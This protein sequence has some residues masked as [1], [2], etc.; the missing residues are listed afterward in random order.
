MYYLFVA[1]RNEEIKSNYDEETI[2]LA[3]VGCHRLD[4]FKRSRRIK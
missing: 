3:P 4:G 2:S 1:I